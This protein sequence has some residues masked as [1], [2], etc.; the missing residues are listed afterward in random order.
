MAEMDITNVLL[1]VLFFV[2]FGVFLFFDLFK[3]NERYSYLAYLVVLLPI[4]YLWYLTSNIGSIFDNINS[5]T[6]FL[7]WFILID[8]CLLRDLMFVYRKTKEFDDIILFLLFGLFIQLIITAI[9]P[10]TVPELQSDTAQLWYFYIPNVHAEPSAGIRVAFQILAT[11]M[12]L[13]AIIPLILDI[14]DEEISLPIIVIISAI[15]YIPFLYLSFVWL[16]GP[17]MFVIA[18]LM[19]VILFI[20]LLIITKSS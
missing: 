6:V 17:V 4:N 13:L 18:F 3:R 8:I 9:L 12:V 16:P 7:I 2:I 15:F 11:L 5:L 10:N 14:K 19:S 1:L 20:L